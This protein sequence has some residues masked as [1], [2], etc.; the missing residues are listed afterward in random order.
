MYKSE[1][2]R[3]I[4]DTEKRGVKKI[5]VGS[6]YS[7]RSKHYGDSKGPPNPSHEKKVFLIGRD[8][9]DKI[10]LKF[11]YVLTKQPSASA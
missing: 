6:M 5:P 10:F 8:G 3:I 7:G 4:T 2:K 11:V 9:L 1:R